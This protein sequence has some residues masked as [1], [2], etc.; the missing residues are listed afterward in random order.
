LVLGGGVTGMVAALGLAQ[1]GYPV[2]LVEREAWLALI[3]TPRTQKKME[4]Y[5]KTGR[6][7]KNSA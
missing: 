2:H 5:L 7:L 6:Y 3:G 1:Q 4:Y